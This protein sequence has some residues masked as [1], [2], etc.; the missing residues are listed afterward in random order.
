[1]KLLLSL[2]P[3]FQLPGCPYGFSRFCAGA[4][5]HRKFRA[6]I[7]YTYQ[8]MAESYPRYSSGYQNLGNVYAEQG[9][10]DYQ[11]CQRVLTGDDQSAPGIRTWRYR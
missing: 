1:M 9:H 3:G 2:N 8:E 4:F 5:F 10:Y 7:A 11:C 6:R